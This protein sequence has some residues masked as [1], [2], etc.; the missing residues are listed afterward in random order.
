MAKTVTVNIVAKVTADVELGKNE[1]IQE[2]TERLVDIY[3]H[4]PYGGYQDKRDLGADIIE[5]EIL[6]D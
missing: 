5:I 1:T 4:G 3:L 6:K 2:L